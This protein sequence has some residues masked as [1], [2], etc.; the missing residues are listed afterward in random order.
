M[1]LRLYNLEQAAK[2][3]RAKADNFFRLVGRRAKDL[4]ERRP[5][6]QDVQGRRP[7]VA[8]LERGK[9][10]R[11]VRLRGT[12]ASAAEKRTRRILEADRSFDKAFVGRLVCRD[13]KGRD[14]F[15]DQFLLR[16]SR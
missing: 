3:I 7:F 10:Q 11:I 14:I 5:V 6:C 1:K 15:R 4:G 2:I 9:R 16:R 12:T 8:V 13:P